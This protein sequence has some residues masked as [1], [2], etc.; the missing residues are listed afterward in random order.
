MELILRAEDIGKRYGDR[1][2][3]SSASLRA[4][5]GRITALVGR[6]G[7]GKST[8][9]K[10]CAG[11]LAS[12]SGAVHFNGSVAERPWL[13]RLARRGLCYLPAD[14]NLLSEGFTLRLQL[15]AVCRQRKAPGYEDAIESLDLVRVLDQRPTSMSG[16]EQ[17]RASLAM[18]MVL[19]PA[20]LMADEPLRGIAPLDMDRICLALRAMRA[21]GCAIVVTGHELTTLFDLVDD[22]VWM[23][24]GFTQFMGT[25]ASAAGDWRFRQQFIGP[26]AH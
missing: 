8:L 13:H 12:E 16:G 7:A 3:L 1:P 24:N 10:I 22:V 25:A 26:A 5:A 9:L 23:E 6:N 20:C 19:E 2:V 4:Q 21:R 15:E 14:R 17:R 11:V 18:A